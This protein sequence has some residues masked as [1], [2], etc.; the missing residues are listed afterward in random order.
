MKNDAPAGGMPGMKMG[1]ITPA[2]DSTRVTITEKG[3]EPARVT[4]SAAASVRLT[5]VRTTE[6]PIAVPSLNIK[7]PLPLN[8]PVVI[9]LPQKRGEVAF[10]CGTF[11][12]A[13]WSCSRWHAEE[14]HAECVRYLQRCGR[15]HSDDAVVVIAI[16]YEP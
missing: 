1:E 3:L 7:R 4:A 14:A 10:T 12:G 2:A 11:W 16:R 15:H 5:F 6:N 13:C 9:E 8:E